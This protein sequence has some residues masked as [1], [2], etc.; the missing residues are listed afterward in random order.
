MFFTTT[1]SSLWYFTYH[2]SSTDFRH[3]TELLAPCISL[4]LSTVNCKNQ[5]SNKLLLAISILIR[6]N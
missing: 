1:V 4:E 5:C 6:Y 2:N 3:T